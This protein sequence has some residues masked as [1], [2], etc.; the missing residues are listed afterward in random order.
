MVNCFTVPLSG[1][2]FVVSGNF[3]I[4]IKLL[5]ELSK[6]KQSGDVEGWLSIEDLR[7]SLRLNP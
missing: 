2:C 7:K 6:G 4:T 1:S 5:S 3:V